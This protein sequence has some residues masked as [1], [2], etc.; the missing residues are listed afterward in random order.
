MNIVSLQQKLDKPKIA[1]LKFTTECNMSCE[2]CYQH[3]KGKI[4]LSNTYSEE[5]M[6]GIVKD[7]KTFVKG[8]T[9]LSIIGGEVSL[10]KDN[11]KK[12]LEKIAS[13]DIKFNS[14]CVVSNGTFKDDFIDMLKSINWDKISKFKPRLVVSIDCSEELHNKKRARNGVG[15]YAN[16]KANILKATD[17]LADCMD[18]LT[19]TVI[20]FNSLNDL[21]DITIDVDGLNK[22]YRRMNIIPVYKMDYTDK[23]IKLHRELCRNIEKTIVDLL[24]SDELV[25]GNIL[26]ALQGLD[27]LHLKDILFENIM[28]HRTCDIGYLRSYLPDGSITSC[29]QKIDVK[30]DNE[31]F[32]A[33]NVNDPTVKDYTKLMSDTIDKDSPCFECKFNGLCQG[34]CINI[35]D[36]KNICI[37]WRRVQSANMFASWNRILNIPNFMKKYEN[38]LIRLNEKKGDSYNFIYDFFMIHKEDIREAVKIKYGIELE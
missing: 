20:D 8:R 17:E 34:S 5:T 9:D 33:G 7:M 12:M 26:Y 18:V 6:N 14:I 38:F 37:P 3:Q 36:M 4:D 35:S 31:Y 32:T 21:S 23:D 24:E 2:Y 25:E 1:I 16:V 10:F 22:N 28:G 13:E 11:I 30:G 15:L 19:S 29:H 27:I